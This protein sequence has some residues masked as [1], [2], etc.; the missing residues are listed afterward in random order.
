M[1]AG[2]QTRHAAWRKIN[3]VHSAERTHTHRFIEKIILRSA[4]WVAAVA[5]Q[6]VFIRCRTCGCVQAVSGVF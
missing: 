3:F 4:H 1:T 6:E 2:L 5:T